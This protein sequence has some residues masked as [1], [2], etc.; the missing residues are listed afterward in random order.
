M[1]MN[2]KEQG[3][4][5]ANTK[6]NMNVHED[7]TDMDM[8]D[9]IQK[10][11]IVRPVPVPHHHH[12]R[13]S[14]SLPFAPSLT[15]TNAN[16][17]VDANVSANVNPRP[18][19]SSACC[20]LPSS[21]MSSS[22]LFN[23]GIH[24]GFSSVDKVTSHSNSH[25]TTHTH[26]SKSNNNNS[27]LD[28][29]FILTS[30]SV[31]IPCDDDEHELD[32][33]HRRTTY[34]THGMTNTDAPSDANSNSNAKDP[35]STSTSTSHQRERPLSLSPFEPLTKDRNYKGGKIS[36][37]PRNEYEAWS[38]RREREWKSMMVRQGMNPHM[39]R[40]GSVGVG[41]NVGMKGR[42]E[43]DSINTFR[44][45][46]VSPL[47]CKHHVHQKQNEEHA[48][49]HDHEHE[50]QESKEQILSLT[51]PRSTSTTGSRNANGS[52]L[53][54]TRHDLMRENHFLKDRIVQLEQM[55]KGQEHAQAQ[56]GIDASPLSQHHETFHAHA[57]R[58]C[59]SNASTSTKTNMGP[60]FTTSANQLSP[61]FESEQTTT[62]TPIDAHAHA[63]PYA[64]KRSRMDLDASY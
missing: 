1:N 32:F 55:L 19:P 6:S 42:E 20:Q 50:P 12:H 46:P 15:R 13:R 33:L 8:M 47:E 48:M 44:P 58:R 36:P 40:N 23:S 11:H 26:G 35:M 25:S 24:S 41:R 56:N 17:D 10:S 29:S 53:S 57:F 5:H 9:L 2:Q 51:R 52:G 7:D 60:S 28:G 31:R 30:Q 37:L 54:P 18:R 14:A 59:P 43:S 39:G 63:F 64:R 61:V 4:A 38:K 16:M 34:N 27:N 49:D 22:S 21:S 3:H 62:T 45:V